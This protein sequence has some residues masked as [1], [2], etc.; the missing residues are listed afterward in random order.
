[1]GENFCVACNKYMVDAASLKHHIR[2]KPHKRRI[3]KLT[4]EPYSQAEAEQSAG[5]GTYIPR[6]KTV[7]KAVLHASAA[8]ANKVAAEGYAETD[9]LKDGETLSSVMQAE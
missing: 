3:N 7:S 6:T 5:L 9:L 4:A 1:M 2:S 8:A